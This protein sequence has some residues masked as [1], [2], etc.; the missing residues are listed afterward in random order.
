MSDN[1][2]KITKR[3]SIHRSDF[4]GLIE[5]P[6]THVR[7]LRFRILIETNTDIQEILEEIEELS[8]DIY[9]VDMVNANTTAYVYFYSEKDFAQFRR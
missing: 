6:A 4:L 3:N 5:D 7:F 1:F 2:I 8:T 9:Y